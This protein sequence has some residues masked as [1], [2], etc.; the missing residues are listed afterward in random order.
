MKHGKLM[1]AFIGIMMLTISCE[2]EKV[3]TPD[4][5]PQAATAYLQ[6]TQPESKVLFAKK[7]SEFLST[8]YKVQLDN[9][10]EFE[11]DGDGN[12]IDID[13]DD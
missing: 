3:I 5:L 9:F 11:F 10:M 4:Q 6:Q 12:V 2:R 13:V 8:K 1:M 7:E